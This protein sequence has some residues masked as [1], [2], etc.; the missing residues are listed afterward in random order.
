MQALETALGVS[1]SVSSVRETAINSLVRRLAKAPIARP[2]TTTTTIH[3]P[4]SSATD[5]PTSSVPHPTSTTTRPG[6][7]S[8]DV[9][10]TLENAGFLSVTDGSSSAFTTFPG[11][12]VDVLV[13]TGDDSHFA[14]SDLT[15]TFARAVSGAGL[16]AVVGAV[17]DGS[18][19]P[20][21]ERGA[22]LAPILDDESLAATV[23]TVDDLELV[24]GQAAAVLS[25]PI[26][27][28]DSAG[29]Y[30]YGTGASAPLP[31]HPS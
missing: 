17:Y 16:P 7:P 20:A 15:A 14:G 28:S 26:A 31:P 22:S 24:Q 10:T 2:P 3:K 18:G 8:S 6:T 25:L 21:P 19:N 30:G 13:I 9:L 4:A 5:E 23:S 1:G 11:H 27:G 29:H 12:A